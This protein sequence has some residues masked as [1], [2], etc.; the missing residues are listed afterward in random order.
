LLS[1]SE[2]ERAD[3]IHGLFWWYHAWRYGGA[4]LIAAA[5]ILTLYSAFGYLWKN[6]ALFAAS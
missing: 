2:F 4:I 6:R 5:L 1:L 3:L